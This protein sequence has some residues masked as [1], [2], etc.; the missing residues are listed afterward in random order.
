MSNK[1][2]I[3]YVQ[4]LKPGAAQEIQKATHYAQQLKKAHA[5]L[6]CAHALSQRWGT[7]DLNT[8]EL[9][10]SLQTIGTLTKSMT[11]IQKLG[12]THKKQ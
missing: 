3:H 5:L 4:L 1:K 9:Q 8:E 10:A 12:V 6:L 11:T 2:G 7:A